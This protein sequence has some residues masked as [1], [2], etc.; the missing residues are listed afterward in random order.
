MHERGRCG[1]LGLSYSLSA[2]AFHLQVDPAKGDW[3]VVQKLCK[4]YDVMVEFMVNHISPAS[5]E[6]QDFLKH[7]MDSKYA[8]MFIHW[9]DF[10][11]GGT[12]DP[13]VAWLH[14]VFSSN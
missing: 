14:P 8:E 5:D 2:R 6:F 11:E 7:G 4:K 10:W 3:E 13:P 12:L 9:N 1:N